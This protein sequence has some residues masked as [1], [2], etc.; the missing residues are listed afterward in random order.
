MLQQIGDGLKGHKWLTYVVFGALALIFAAWGAYGISNLSFGSSSFIA[1]VNGTT[2]PYADVRS[3]WQREQA[4]WQQ[5]FGGDI[6]LGER[7]VLQ[8]QIL[9]KAIR[10]T[11]ITDR[12]SK[13][14]Y[15]VS[16]AQIRSALRA[17]QAFQLDGQ[18]NADVAKS[19]LAQAGLTEEQYENDLRSDL[20]R[21]ELQDGLQLSQFVT[22]T[23]LERL[24][25]LTDQ[26]RQ[27]RFA[28]LPLDKYA[29][30]VAVTDAAIQAYYDA[31]KSQFLTPESVHLA[32]AQA[33]LA[34]VSA[35]ITVSDADLT[36]YYNKN[37]NRYISTEQRHAHHIL[38]AV[39][40]KVDAAAALK[41]AQDLEAKL[42][43]GGNFEALAKQSSDD[44]GSAVQGGDLG[45][46]ER[47]SLEAPFGDA[48]F[49]MK[50]GEVSAPI[51]TKFGYHIIRLDEI[52]PAKGKTF[53]EARADVLAQLKHD[54]AADKF[55]D[56]QEQVQQ[57]VDQSGGTLETLAKEFALTLGDI[58]EYLKGTGGGDL[59]STPELQALV[60]GDAVLGEHKIGGPLLLGDERLVIVKDLSHA[61][62]APKPLAAVHDLIVALLRKESGSK[63]ALA[64]ATA[65][66]S[67]LESG[68]DFDAVA[69][70][71]GVTAEAARFVG[72]Q[73]PS[74][75][76]QI[77][78][79]AF[80]VAKPAE[81]QAVYQ[82]L[83]QPDGGAVVLGVTAVRVEA[84][85]TDKQQI[86]ALIRDLAAQYAEDDGTAYVEQARREAKVQKNIEL[87]DQQ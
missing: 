67:S 57:K 49:A 60:F 36:E 66:A 78:D 16:E 30:G 59:G 21:R 77:R 15:R 17:E 35:Q 9:E 87:F 32:Y 11:L 37:K 79:A 84:A 73:D 83:A 13:L 62:P 2:I 45:L 12:A 46:A 7:S 85:P 41:K 50:P 63:A 76:A 33:S 82:A 68:K 65:A 10:T 3:A 26:E 39:N 58:P 51:H 72:R 31:H 42:K 14:G 48:L 29:A 22:P 23:E 34:Q 86:S 52:V 71:L 5:R 19:R 27:I 6:P 4:Q 18:Y 55:G 56:L 75:P 40:D 74:V 38:V 24:H 47:G 80:K 28:V 8:D 69:K 70:E 54:R 25:A 64:A 43:A 81:H 61:L 20:E 44:A 53:A 1:K